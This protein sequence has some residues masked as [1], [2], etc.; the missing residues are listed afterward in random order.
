MKFVDMMK[1]KKRNLSLLMTSLIMV[2]CAAGATSCKGNEGDSS[3]SSVSASDS[4]S[5]VKTYY[6]VTFDVNG[7]SAI[8]SVSVLD[9]ETVAKPNTNPTKDGYVFVG[10]YTNNTYTVPFAFGSTAITG[11]TT[12]YAK[13]VQ[14]QADAVEY[15]VNYV[16]D[17]AAF[18]TATT[19]NGAVYQLPTPTK[20]GATFAGWWKSDYNDAAKLTAKFEDGT[21]INEDITLYAVWES[22]APNVSVVGNTISWTAKGVNNQYIV[23]VFAENGT[24]LATTTTP[25]SSYTF[26]FA[27]AAEG[28]YVVEVTLNGN[29]AKAY[30]KNKALAKVKGFAYVG[31]DLVW[32]AVP[33]ATSYLVSI[34]CG[35]PSHTHV[36]EVVTTNAYDFKDCAMKADGIKFSVKAAADGY[37]T[38]DA[39]EFVVIKNL[40]AVTNLA[41]DATTAKFTWDAVENAVRYN[42]TVN[43]ETATTTEASFDAK[44]LTG[45]IT[46]SV[47]PATFGYNSPDAVE[48]TVNKTSLPAPT[49][50]KLAGSNITWN[51]V[52][53]ATGYVV[54]VDEKEYNV[55]D[56]SF[57]IFTADNI[58]ADAA[59]C[60]VSIKAVGATADADSVYS[61]VVQVGF[62]VMSDALVY[63]K[64][65]ISWQPVLNV[66]GYEVQVNNGDII[67][68]DAD[69]EKAAVT[70]TQKGENVIKVR[71]IDASNNASEWVETVVNAYEISFNFG[72]S[73]ETAA[74]V[75]LATGDTL[76]LPTNTATPGYEFAGWYNAETNG[77]KYDGASVTFEGVADQVVY[78]YWNANTYTITYK[79]IVNGVWKEGTQEVTYGKSYTLPVIS[80][81]T[82]EGLVFR[83]WFSEEN[84]QGIEY[85]N[86][87]GESKSVWGGLQD[88]TVYAHKAEGFKYEEITTAG[89]L[90][91]Y[92]VMAGEAF[93]EVSELTIPAMYNG[94]PV[95]WIDANAFANYTTIKKLH[96]PDSIERIYLG[97]D[98]AYSGAGSAFYGCA[99][100]EEIDIYDA[101]ASMDGNYQ[102][103]YKSIDG[104]LVRLTENNGEELAFVPVTKTGEYRIPDSITSLAINLFRSYTNFDKIIVPATV[105]VIEDGA[106]K[107][108]KAMEIVLEDAEG[109]EELVL[110]ADVF[111]WLD[112]ETFHIPARMC[113]VD[114]LKNL[115]YQVDTLKSITVAEDNAYYSANA[116]M[117]FDKAGTTLLYCPRGMSGTVTIPNGTQTIE[118]QAFGHIRLDKGGAVDAC[119]EIQKVIIPASVTTIKD[120]A[121][122]KCPNLNSVE[123]LG[124]AGDP[125]INIGARAFYGTL[126]T[127]L[128]LP[129]NTGSVAV[130][131]FGAIKNLNAVTIKAGEGFSIASGAFAD[132]NTGEYYVT[133]LNLAKCVPVFD[134]NG[135]FGPIK[136][137]KVNF[138]E[139]ENDYMELVDD[140]LFDKG[141]TSIIY[142]PATK[143]LD[144]YEIPATVTSIGSN[145][146]NSKSIGEIVIPY[147]TTTIAENAFAN[148][149][150]LKKISFAA[151]PADAADNEGLTIADGAF[152]NNELLASV[153]L[154][155]YTKT[156]GASAFRNTGL[157]GTFVIPEGVTSVG[158]LA[159]ENCA[160]LTSVSIPKSL[161]D[162]AYTTDKNNT[163]YQLKMFNGCTSLSSITVASGNTKFMTKEGILYEHVDGVPTTLVFCPM[164]YEIAGGAA[165]FEIPDTVR[166]IYA[167][168]FFGNTSVQK[169]TFAE[170]P[171]GET[172]VIQKNAFEQM[173]SL[174]EVILGKGVK[175]ISAGMFKNCSALDHVFIPNTLTKINQSSPFTGCSALTNLEFEEGGSEE[176]VIMGGNSYAYTG[177]SGFTGLSGITELTLPERYKNLDHYVFW[178][179]SSMHTINLPSTVTSMGNSVFSGCT[180]LKNV[181]IAQGDG[182]IALSIGSSL[183]VG[184]AVESIE[185]PARTT[186]IG[187]SAF[188]GTAISA[189]TIPANVT[190]IGAN[191]FQNCESLTEVIFA[192]G[193]QLKTIGN[194]A[195]ANAALTSFDVPA[196]VE[197]IGQYAFAFMDGFTAINFAAETALKKIDNYA[198]R[199]T[200]LT[201]LNVPV[202]TNAI[203]LGE[204]LFQYCTDL[205]K[206]TISA[207]VT[208][209]AK[210]FASCGS[211]EEVIVDPDN[212]NFSVDGST[213]YN[214]DK[215]AIKFI[216]AP[217]E[218]EDGVYRIVDGVTEIAA[219]A[220]RGQSDIKTLYIPATVTTI[221]ANAFEACV[222]LEEVIFENAETSACQTISNNAFDNCYAL[223]KIIL[224]NG[225]N[226][227]GDYAFRNCSSLNEIA[228]NGVTTIGVRAFYR[229]ASLESVTF[230]DSLAAINSYA[231]AESGLKRVTLPSALTFSS[232]TSSTESSGRLGIFYNCKSLAKV[233]IPDGIQK[234]GYY[235][236]YG[237]TALESIDVPASVT[238]FGLGVFRYSGLK[239]FEFKHASPTLSTYTFQGCTNLETVKLPS[240]MA[241]IPGYTF[242]GCTSLGINAAEGESGVIFPE[243]LTSIQNYA[244]TDCTSLKYIKLPESLTFLA[245]NKKWSN[246]A[247]AFTFQGC[248][249][250]EKVTLSTGM[251]QLGGYVFRDCV[252]L[253]TVENLDNVE[254]V[255]TSVFRNTAI[256]SIA[257][258]KLTNLGTYV[259]EG[260]TELASV[261]LGSGITAIAT[262]AFQNTPA[263]TAIRIPSSVSSI[264][265][266]AFL[267][268]A[269]ESIT[270]PSSISTISAETFMDCANLT[271]VEF[272]GLVIEIGASAF[273]NCSNLVNLTMP[274]DLLIIGAGAFM[275]TG[276]TNVTLSAT[277]NS[278]G[279]KAFADCPDLV[280][281][282]IHEDNPY[283]SVENNVIKNYKGEYVYA[284]PGY[285]VTDGKLIITDDSNVLSEAGQAPFAGNTTITEVVVTAAWTEVPAEFF[286]GMRGLT[287]V[288][289]P[290]SVT[291]IGNYAFADATAL[292]SVEMPG[293]TSIGDYAFAGCDSLKTIELP[294]TLESIGT[295]A[296]NESGLQSVNVPGS[297]K[298]IGTYA[299]YA[300]KDLKAV[301]LNEG[302]ESIDLYAFS[303]TGIES[304]TIPAT[305][306]KFGSAIRVA[307]PGNSSQNSMV[308]RSYAFA[309]CTALKTVV[310][311][312]E[313]VE[314]T[315]NAFEGC[316]ALE[317]VTLPSALTFVGDYM[318]YGCTALKTITL[319]NAVTEL[320]GYAFAYSG[321]TTIT[322]PESLTII[323]TPNNLMDSAVADANNPY[324]TGATQ[325]NPVMINPNGHT[326]TGCTELTTVNMLGDVTY[327]GW[328]S[329]EGCTKLANITLPN[330]VEVIGDYAFAN[331]DSL[332][333]LALPE[334]LLFIGNYAFENGKMASIVIPEKAIVLDNAFEGWTE[335]QTI[336]V[337]TS[338]YKAASTWNPAW[339]SGASAIIVWAYEEA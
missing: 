335:T 327:I 231:F 63:S 91:A 96:I 18:E 180:N 158:D 339:F 134:V 205:T 233:T 211:L 127:S 228:M 321:L 61:D 273:Q 49:G 330:T 81:Y 143:V 310:F 133:T 50:I 149:V 280:S 46:I 244:F 28:N 57:D 207:S 71:C 254:R 272:E 62:G 294:N 245:A 256:E 241:D 74:P 299:F 131:A 140:V 220:F 154:P 20:D 248:T 92:S 105:K 79:Y 153:V 1:N 215:T 212:A 315:G 189:I 204:C 69:T 139:G 156:I 167:Y 236:F 7:G 182:A 19:V 312:G 184:T 209:A 246:G 217:V 155:S 66:K 202:S 240:S 72:A 85:T 303:E 53:G 124:V 146:F 12:I 115:F 259:F 78:A 269:I 195:F 229:C 290:A 268:S 136:L 6:T 192:E 106:F 111:M 308:E 285:T 73:P 118:T 305:V 179:M 218:T 276:L 16:V 17:G 316:T 193:S 151:K 306:T 95:A 185:L 328:Y 114:D 258:P 278:I 68:V 64:G 263:L 43:G 141:I 291:A 196:T 27:N 277:V 300:A 311:L 125:A 172:I 113:Q 23:K 287:K 34:E 148:G 329:F 130:N 178:G 318:F 297:V 191:A 44:A 83:G 274:N 2:G 270:I 110:G 275:G 145:V 292:E 59:S 255:E 35:D 22:N 284:L 265:T 128:E 60:N 320:G 170:L 222:N 324:Q 80:E 55:T 210:T 169:I 309:N 33:N 293:V 257:L 144:V 122:E 230:N 164:N 163:Y 100:L 135:A 177:S 107:S 38:G 296:F 301:T 174:T 88:T 89:G 307:E 181:N 186:S 112:V 175:E 194:Y 161:T 208:N 132:S 282:T 70:F 252:N 216:Y 150:Q 14:V 67:S 39:G 221:G 36:D 334:S 120:S 262:G 30:Y 289:L 326:F 261:T 203:T 4:T 225:V 298:T 295:C 11:N 108:C 5:D 239:S 51:A 159:F 165:G 338:A 94:K 325:K 226:K 109:A 197:T 166:T 82:T 93:G 86:N 250:L 200:G 9:G 283:F 176:L 147:A 142:Y 336:N 332:T 314:A 249:S 337:A 26:D 162:L 171:A 119:N 313:D 65:E 21:T 29:T 213:V 137:S 56:A 75:Y 219:G 224:P 76:T 24:E 279:Y 199:Q 98:G 138:I 126:L 317:N 267:G 160:N 8:E 48:L 121:F 52:D 260:C 286:S 235:M 152:E 266:N 201:E 32:E 238:T 322:L 3:D 101:S 264:G 206:V 302:L 271:T 47:V 13:F 331:C 123:F 45:D 99:G 214:A 58:A 242:Q 232:V 25:Q 168:A 190:S 247:N 223:R 31:S 234:L 90:A 97:L 281:F 84:G 237:C 173:T 54:K 253:K 188:K 243:T 87:L 251:K 333:T 104:A 304:I 77:V 198:F 40:N 187:G 41:Y 129:A 157:T 288:T 227:I 103:Y 117:L 116:G 37:M 15:N 10:W 319:P 183:F 42:V 102:K 323:G